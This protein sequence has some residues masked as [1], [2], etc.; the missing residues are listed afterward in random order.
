MFVININND[1][2][3]NEIY[4]HTISDYLITI[5]NTANIKIHLYFSN[6][7]PS[8]KLW[9]AIKFVASYLA[10]INCRLA[11]MESYKLIPMSFSKQ[12][13]KPPASSSSGEKWRGIKAAKH[14][15][16]LKSSPYNKSLEK[17]ASI[18]FCPVCLVTLKEVRKEFAAKKPKKGLN[19]NNETATKDRTASG[20]YLWILKGSMRFFFSGDAIQ[21]FKL[22]NIFS[23]INPKTMTMGIEAKKG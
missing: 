5:L 23:Y 22:S 7:N 19:A 3:I 16:N 20:E 8:A 21:L 14:L 13:L 2:L 6:L 12:Y 10:H 9:P 4:E 18:A 11:P 1:K 17:T 15:G